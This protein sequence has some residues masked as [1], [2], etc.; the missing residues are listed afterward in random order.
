MLSQG[1]LLI[2]AALFA[3]CFAQNCTTC[4][5]P[6]SHSCCDSYNLCCGSKYKFLPKKYIPQKNKIS[7]HFPQPSVVEQMKHVA[8]VTCVAEK[9]LSVVWQQMENLRCV[10][11][12]EN[13]AVM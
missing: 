1:K 7:S 10:V 5:S 2:L 6:I 12:P 8:K 4:K 13:R 9:D 3:V 11:C